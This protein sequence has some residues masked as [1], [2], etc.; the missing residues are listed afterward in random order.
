MLSSDLHDFEKFFRKLLQYLFFIKFRKHDIWH[1]QLEK[2]N[3]LE[4]MT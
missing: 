2:Y 1:K 3:D 4:I